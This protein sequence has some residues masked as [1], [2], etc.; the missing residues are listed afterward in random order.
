MNSIEDEIFKEEKKEKSRFSENFISFLKTVIKISFFIGIN[1]FGFYKSKKENIY[2]NLNSNFWRKYF[3]NS[4]DW[5]KLL[6]SGVLPSISFWFLFNYFFNSLLN[7]KKKIK[8]NTILTIKNENQNKKIEFNEL[9][10]SI[11]RSKSKNRKFLIQS[12]FSNSNFK[13]S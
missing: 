12:N 13:N 10:N 8:Q 6:I 4:F 2:W 11:A 7:F 3:I 1:L 9:K 5:K